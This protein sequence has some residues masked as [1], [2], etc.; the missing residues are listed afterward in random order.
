MDQ[1][2]HMRICRFVLLAL[3]LGFALAPTLSAGL[4]GVTIGACWNTVYSG[5]ATVDTSQCDGTTVGFTAT[6]AVVADP[7][8]EFQTQ[9]GTRLVDFTDNTVTVRYLSFS[10][11]PSP[12]LFIFTGLPGTITGLTLLTSNP[13]SVTTAFGPTS[14]GLLV[15]APECCASSTV[16]VTYQIEGISTVPEPASIALVGIGFLLGGWFVRR[17]RS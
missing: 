17:R 14:I 1:G 2:N 12:D 4:I 9:A 15:G 6:S 8:V 5:S 10:G 13:L 7:G 11:S 3:V 16:D